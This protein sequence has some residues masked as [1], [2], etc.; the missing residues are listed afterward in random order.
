MVFEASSFFPF[1]WNC[2]ERWVCIEAAAAH[3]NRHTYTASAIKRK[4]AFRLHDQDQ[5][6]LVYSAL[7]MHSWAYN[8]NNFSGT[9]DT[10]EKKNRNCALWIYNEIILWFAEKFTKEFSGSFS[11]NPKIVRMWNETSP[12]A[13]AAFCFKPQRNYLRL[14]KY[15]TVLWHHPAL[16]PK[17]LS[18]LIHTPIH[19]L[20]H[21]SSILHF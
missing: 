1:F 9:Q 8:N 13:V 4:I 3:K 6:Y 16:L 18:T 19:I 11:H 5:W 2:N 10:K 14:L 21:I 12:S 17:P 15:K 7:Y 20:I